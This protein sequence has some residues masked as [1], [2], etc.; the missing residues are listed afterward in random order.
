M[1][2]KIIFLIFS[3]FF[4]F[5]FFAQDKLSGVVIDSISGK[6]IPDVYIMMMDE[7]GKSILSYSFSQ[8]NGTFII[9]FPK[10]E[11]STFLLTTSRIG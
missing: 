10:T 11:Q 2:R 4:I 7:D 1:K 9:G 6:P 5:G 3:S 8:E